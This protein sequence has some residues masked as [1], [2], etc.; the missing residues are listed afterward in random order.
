MS[1]FGEDEKSIIDKIVLGSGFSRNFINIFDSL[2]RLQ[3]VRISVDPAARSAEYLFQITNANPTQQELQ[4]GI[5]REKQLTQEL[6]TH[7]LVLESLEKEGLAFFYSPASPS[8]GNVVFGAGAVNMP[9]FS[10]S[11]YDNKIID[12]LIKYVHLEVVPKTE[13]VHLQHNKYKSK[14][15]ANYIFPRFL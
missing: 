3:G 1:T 5:E 14:R 10:M 2:Q 15:L 8:T 9:S 12:L 4:A 13:L 6:I 11:I 7:L